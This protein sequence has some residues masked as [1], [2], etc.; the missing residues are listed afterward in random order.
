MRGP[1]NVPKGETTDVVHAHHL[2]VYVHICVY[3]YWYVCLVTCVVFTFQVV[4]THVDAYVCIYLYVYVYIYIYMCV[5]P[6][7]HTSTCC[8]FLYGAATIFQICGW[9]LHCD[10][11]TGAHIDSLALWTSSTHL[12]CQ[13]PRW[14]LMGLL[15]QYPRPPCSFILGT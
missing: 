5:N 13:T 3:R 10:I 6:I 2:Y 9:Y 8:S 12:W 15:P 1:C 4:S 11:L 14:S 7:Y